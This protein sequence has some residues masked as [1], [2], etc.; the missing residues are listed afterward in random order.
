MFLSYCCLTPPNKYSG[1]PARF[2]ALIEGALSQDGQCSGGFVAR[3]IPPPKTCGG[4]EREGQADKDSRPSST[5]RVR[6]CHERLD[7]PPANS[8]Q[9][10]HYIAS[11]MSSLYNMICTMS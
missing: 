1:S 3:Y 2:L 6:S 4:G 11:M 8:Q 9:E 10:Y 5:W 7:L